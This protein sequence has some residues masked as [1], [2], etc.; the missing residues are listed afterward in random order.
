MGSLLGRVYIGVDITVGA[1][2]VVGVGGT[3]VVADN[4]A[5]VRGDSGVVGAAV[6]AEPVCP[7][8]ARGSQRLEIPNPASES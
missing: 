2:A 4:L 3:E 5:V 8:G 7:A 6:G 1:S